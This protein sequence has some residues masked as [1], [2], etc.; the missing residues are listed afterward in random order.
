MTPAELFSPRNLVI[1]TA[2]LLLAPKGQA[3]EPAHALLVAPHG[4]SAAHA[5]RAV[6]PDAALARLMAGARR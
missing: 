1:A 5:A 3:A 4:V 2:A 6:S